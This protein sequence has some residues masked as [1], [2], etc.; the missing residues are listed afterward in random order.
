MEFVLIITS[1]GALICWIME[2]VAAFKNEE[3]PLLGILSIIPCF[4]LGG[5]IIGWINVGKWNLS[6]VMYIWTALVVLHLIIGFS[7][8]AFTGNFGMPQMN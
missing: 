6:T 7:T 4:G 8:G 3:S 1:I 5:F 2:I